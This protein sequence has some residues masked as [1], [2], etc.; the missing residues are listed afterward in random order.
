MRQIGIRLRLKGGRVVALLPCERYRVSES[1]PALNKAPPYCKIAQRRKKG[2]WTA[3][4]VRI[5]LW[6][7]G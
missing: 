7:C 6:D 3:D 1:L 2:N 5:F 4:V